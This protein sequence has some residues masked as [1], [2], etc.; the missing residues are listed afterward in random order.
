[1]LNKI[2]KISF[3]SMVFMIPALTF[4]QY[5]NKTDSMLDSLGKIIKDKLIP[6]L[7]ALALLLF[8]WGLVKYIWSL[9]SGSKEEGKNI[10]VWGIIAL[11]VM[12]SVWG[13]VNFI[14]KSLDLDN[15]GSNSITIPTIN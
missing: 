9:S 8:F 5:F 3:V 14:R 6:L 11:T 10:M 12:I 2:Y 15:P 13:L 1:M 4:A 7:F